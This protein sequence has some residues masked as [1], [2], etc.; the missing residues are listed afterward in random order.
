[1]A[2]MRLGRY[3]LEVTV[4]RITESIARL[5]SAVGGVEVRYTNLEAA[6]DVVALNE[7]ITALQQQVAAQALI[8]DGYALQIDALTARLNTIGQAPTV[9]PDLP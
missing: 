2:K 5:D 3:L 8:E 1:M 7:Q 4:S 9:D 6:P